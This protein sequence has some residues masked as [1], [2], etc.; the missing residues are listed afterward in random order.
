MLLGVNRTDNKQLWFADSQ[1][2]ST[3]S[4]TNPS[5]R[6][7]IAASSA[8]IDC[9]ATN[10]STR[11]N[12][13]IGQNMVH[14]AGGNIQINNSAKLIFN[15]VIDDNR[16]QL[17]TGYGFGINSST[18]RYN[19][20]GSHTFYFGPTINATLTS[21]GNLGIGVTNPRARLDVYNKAMIVRGI[22][23]ADTATIFLGTPF[24]TASA[25]KCAIIAQGV[26]SWSRSTL[27]FCLN[28]V[29]NNADT[30]N[31]TLANARMTIDYNGNVG[32]NNGSPLNNGVLTHLCI[33]SSAIDG[34]DGALVIGKKSGGSTRQFKMGFSSLFYYG[35]GDYGLNNTVG[36]WV[37][38]ISVIYN[39]PASCFT[40]DS[41]GQIS[42]NFL[43]FSD[44]RLKTDINTIENALYKVQQL[45]GVEYTRI[46]ENTREIGLIAQEVEHIIPE[47]VKDNE[48]TGMKGINYSGLIGLLVNAIKEQ[49]QQITEMKEQINYLL[50]K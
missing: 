49:Q 42:G 41:L 36:T 22:G 17:Y 48:L 11:L 13:Q 37:Q 10:G 39:A 12:F 4:T 46:Q 3:T 19:S 21:A 26:N 1:R 34:S 47:A 30:T 9:M 16:L 44:E 29:A 35:L 8:F 45:R 33:G 15:D 40:I 28:N 43:D 24:D 5:V 14:L 50:N 7:G 18:L 20:G 25:L 38:H 32:I 6:M 31:A 2:Y 27:N 23:E